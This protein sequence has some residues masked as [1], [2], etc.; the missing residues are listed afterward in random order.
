MPD[1]LPD[2][3]RLKLLARLARGEVLDVGCRDVQNPFLTAAVGFDLVRPDAVRSN[4]QRFVQGDCQAIDQFFPAASFDTIVAGE[5]IEHLENPSSF[6]R[7]CRRILR[8][9]GQLLI[10]TPNP[11][12]WTTVLGNLFF[13]TSGITYDH[14]SLIPFRAMTALLEHTGW[15]AVDVRNASRGMRLWHTTRKYFLPCPKAL[16]WQHLYVCQKAPA[17]QG[18]GA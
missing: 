8:D 6:L 4:Y 3:K 12:H 16:A 10:T 7:A 5:L 2:V 15:K 17:A 1:D 11:Y 9:S 14:L 18:D 13:M